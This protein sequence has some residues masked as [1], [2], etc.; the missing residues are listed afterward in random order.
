[1]TAATSRRPPL[2]DSVTVVTGFVTAPQAWSV[3][4]ATT[5]PPGAVHRR[6]TPH[7]PTPLPTS[8]GGLSGPSI[9]AGGER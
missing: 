8:L 3:T 5:A 9:R 1:M 6:P 7:P 4:V 2:R